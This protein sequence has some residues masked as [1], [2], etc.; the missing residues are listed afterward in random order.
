ME[1][2]YRIQGKAAAERANRVVEAIQRFEGLEVVP[3]TAEAA[4]T[5]ARLR[6]KYYQRGE[7]ELSYADAIHL[8]IAVMTDC[9]VLYSGDPDFA[10]LDEIETE[11]V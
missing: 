11:I 3:V 9:D 8:A 2:W 4:L 5:A 1:V 7:R 6:E 10:N